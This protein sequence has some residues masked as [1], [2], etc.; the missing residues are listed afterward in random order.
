[1][2]IYFWLSLPLV[3]FLYAAVGHGGASGYMALMLMFG[4]ATAEVRPAALLLNLG[5]SLLSFWQ[6]YR[7]GYFRWPLFWP[8]ALAS[9]PAA[10]FGGW[11]GLPPYW[12]KKILGLLLLLPTLRL[13]GVWKIAKIDTEKK[14]L[15]LGLALVLGALVGGISGLIGIG[16]GIILS[17]LLLWLAWANVKQAAAVSALF[18]F[19]NS[20]A[21]L[22]GLAQKGF[23]IS[24]DIYFMLFLSMLAGLLGGVWGATWLKNK[25]LEQLLAIVLL[26]ACIKLV[27]E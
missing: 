20:L 23:F 19:V 27:S 16:G 22:A 18:I 24:I 17:P 5:V 2:A 25:D 12:Y 26:L 14:P 11:L 10:Y 8:F 4:M 1:M 21:G 13:F 9:V 15:H 7:A 6:F 3:A